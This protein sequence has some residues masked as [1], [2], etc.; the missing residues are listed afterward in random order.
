MRDPLPS[1]C[2]QHNIANASALLLNGDPKS[3]CVRQTRFFIHFSKSTSF[4]LASPF[5]LGCLFTDGL[6]DGFF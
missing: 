1:L 3:R 6:F 2:G 4:S 5:S